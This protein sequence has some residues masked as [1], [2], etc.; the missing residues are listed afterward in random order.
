MQN[1]LPRSYSKWA[2]GS[3]SRDNFL[4]VQ[5]LRDHP[6][7]LVGTTVSHEMRLCTGP[8]EELLWTPG[9]TAKLTRQ[10]PAVK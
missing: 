7:Y 4:E 10:R 6:G 2:I 8:R 5:T 9:C 3:A 1:S